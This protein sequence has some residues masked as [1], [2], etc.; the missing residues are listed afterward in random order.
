MIERRP[1]GEDSF[2]PLTGE[3]GM[4]SQLS[5]LVAA[6]VLGAGALVWAAPSPAKALTIVSQCQNTHITPTAAACAGWYSGNLLNQTAVA[7]QQAALAT[8]GFSWNG[9]WAAVDATKVEVTDAPFDFGPLLHTGAVI[10]IKIGAAQFGSDATAFFR[11]AQNNIDVVTLNLKGASSGVVYSP[12]VIP[13]PATWGL[14]ILGVGAV[15]ALL[16]RKRQ[17]PDGAATV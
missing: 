15:G 10:G 1:R 16:R 11:L 2:V 5:A 9:N 7:D 4:K 6:S 3:T 8:L 17:E 14:M 13:E 12:G